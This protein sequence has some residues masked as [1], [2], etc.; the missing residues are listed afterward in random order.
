MKTEKIEKVNQT[1]NLITKVTF[2]NMFIV[3]Y[4]RVFNLAII[5]EKHLL[6]SNAF[7]MVGI[8]LIVIVEMLKLIDNRNKL[9][10]PIIFAVIPF[11][12]CIILLF[13]VIAVLIKTLY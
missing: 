9:L 2:L 13:F 10:T 5:T 6:I 3:M 1:L 7:F 4:L 8:Y 11:V 12:L